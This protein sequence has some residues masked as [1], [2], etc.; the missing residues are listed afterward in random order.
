MF[1]CTYG[2]IFVF[3]C[4]NTCF[5]AWIL[6]WFHTTHHNAP[7]NDRSIDSPIHV[8]VIDYSSMPS[9]STQLEQLVGEPSSVTSTSTPTISASTSL[10][11][12]LQGVE[13]ALHIDEFF[14]DSQH[15]QRAISCSGA[16]YHTT[17]QLD[18]SPK[19]RLTT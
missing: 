7:A 5:V 2:C 1:I 11:D 10:E 3:Y 16:H 18:F 8:P 13:D 4:S 17:F 19:S 6:I 14:H 15:S 9:S 12:R